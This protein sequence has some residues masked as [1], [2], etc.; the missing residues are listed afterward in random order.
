MKVEIN[1]SGTYSVEIQGDFTGPYINLTVSP[2]VAY[3]LLLALDQKREEIR[4]LAN[5]YYDC[6]ECG[7]THPKT[8]QTCPTIGQ[9][10]E[11]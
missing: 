7:E 1:R 6:A 9:Q 8:V 10:G 5:N 3:E 2:A 11:E 4:D